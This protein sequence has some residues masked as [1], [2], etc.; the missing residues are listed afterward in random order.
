MTSIDAAHASRSLHARL[1]PPARVAQWLS[2]GLGRI[3][4]WQ[5]RM[6]QRA[7]LS[8]MDERMRKDIGISYADALREADKPFWRG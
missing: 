3:V 6:E 7:A 1:S 2:R 4:E 8:A 5:E